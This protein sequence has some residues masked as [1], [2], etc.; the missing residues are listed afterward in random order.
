MDERIEDRTAIHLVSGTMDTRPVTAREAAAALGVHDRTIRRAIARGELPA[1]KRAGVFEIMPAALARYRSEHLGHTTL[2]PQARQSSRLLPSPP[3]DRAGPSLPRPLTPLVGRE[4]ETAAVAALVRQEDVRLVT[5]TGPGGV[6]KTRLAL[7]VA[8]A[9]ADQDAAAITTWFVP[10]APVTDPTLAPTA[11]AQTL[12]IREHPGRPTLDSLTEF[13]SPRSALL[14]LDNLEHLPGIAPVV[15]ALLSACPALTIL[16]T[17]RIRLR[18]TVEHEWVVPPL[19]SP[20]AITLFFD[21]AR[22]VQPNL[23]PTPDVTAAVAEI[24]ARLD[25]LP[26]AIELAAARTKLLSPTA[27]LARLSNRLQILTGGPQDAPDRHQTMRAAVSWSYDLLSPQD[28]TLFRQLA[29]FAGGATLEA[30]AAGLMTED[31]ALDGVSTLL[32][33]GLVQREDDPDGE[34]RF[35]M[36]ETIRAYA[37]EQLAAHAETEAARHAHATFFAALAG[38][39][40]AHQIGPD[41]GQWLDRLEADLDNVRAAL[42]WAIDTAD[43]AATDL[44]LRLAA[45]SGPYWMNR[46]LIR[47]GTDWLQRVTSRAGGAPHLRAAALRWLGLHERIAGDPDRAE[48]HLT[49]ALA[50]SRQAADPTLT[51]L[52]LLNLGMLASDRSDY[53]RGDALLNEALPIAQSAGNLRGEALIFQNLAVAAERRGDLAR[54]ID[55][56]VRALARFREIGDSFSVA[57]SLLNLGLVDYKAGDFPSAI[58]Y[59]EESLAGFR[60]LGDRT[61]A[62]IALAR[63]GEFHR[64][65]GD[66]PRAVAAYR[67]TLEIQHALGLAIETSNLLMILVGIALAL[68]RP[69]FAARLAGAADA[70]G[71]WRH[72]HQSPE[73][74]AEFDAH[75]AGVRA[76]LGEATYAAAWAVGRAQPLDVLFAD[77]RTLEASDG[78]RDVPSID[79][80]VAAKAL[81]LTP[82]EHEI[83]ALLAQG[84]TDREIAD[85]LFISR[86]TASNHVTAV[87]AKLDL[88][89]RGAVGLFAIRHGLIAGVTVT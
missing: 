88:P 15:G 19:S 54:S 2:A 1:L 7:S 44:A 23:T 24:C 12:G 41:R 37:T 36:L 27:L 45:G 57:I 58:A 60:A 78:E 55:L 66:L 30:V 6:G 51:V 82:R 73:D 80:V 81:G 40:A 52:A 77:L 9:V 64:Y 38:T 8:T 49:E 87:L 70:H 10:L 33:H 62:A 63:V 21:R 83:L 34:P 48:V 28:Q 59:L 61:Y 42:T 16:A 46:G 75:L 79:P 35:R 85:Q 68:G 71:D 18:L 53:D 17:S 56:D 26:L 3:R 72:A 74:V 11:V 20:P 89:T 13:L 32:D 50:C 39:V 67:E 29:V 14:I 25:G 5:L 69:A 22:A 65:R 31:S 47:E 76:A 4:V 86:R 84:L 43:P